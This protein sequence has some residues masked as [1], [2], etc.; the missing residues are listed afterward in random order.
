MTITDIKNSIYLYTKTNSTSLP[1]TNLLLLV[2]NAYERVASLIMK[3]DGVWQWDDNNQS[4]LPIATTTLTANQQDYTLTTDHLAIA[5]VEVKDENGDWRII[6]PIDYSDVDEQAMSEYYET[7]GDPVFYDKI[8]ASIFL[9]P[10]PDYTQ[11]ASLKIYFQRGPALF[12][13]A[14][15]STGTKV[16][17]FNSL[18]HDLIPLWASYNYAI[19]NGLSN[20][21]ALFAEIQRKEDALEADYARRSK[22]RE[23]VLTSQSVC[24]E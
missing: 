23:M 1:T 7:A 20:A 10:K 8:G 9:Y 5:R 3:Y 16:P 6:R 4:D 19:A 18:Y 12:T 11:S 14:E 13:S 15:V 22:D 17:G 2:N 24:S 21:P